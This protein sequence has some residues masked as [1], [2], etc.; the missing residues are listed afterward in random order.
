M[1]GHLVVSHFH[2]CLNNSDQIVLTAVS[3]YIWVGRDIHNNDGNGF[4]QIKGTHGHYIEL[5]A[6]FDLIDSLLIHLLCLLK[7][8]IDELFDNLDETILN[9][10]SMQKEII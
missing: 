9:Q 7:E 1:C 5:K 3:L 4:D 10:L 8:H 6:F 2:A